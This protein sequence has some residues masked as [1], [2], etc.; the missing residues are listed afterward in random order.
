MD[1]TARLAPLG[2]HRLRLLDC[3]GGNSPHTPGFFAAGEDDI[4]S[5]YRHH[6]QALWARWGAEPDVS[7]QSLLAAA[8]LLIGD[9][10]AAHVIVNN[11]PET[12]FALDH[13]AGFCVVAPLHALRA[14]LPLPQELADTTLWI[15]R[16]AEQEALR[17]WLTRHGRE[18]HWDETAAEYRLGARPHE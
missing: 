1:R 16:S 6:V 13:G 18:L 11:L 17:A 5:A 4:F 7:M 8:R 15:A 12:A 2:F 14:A 10:A 9:L 3:L